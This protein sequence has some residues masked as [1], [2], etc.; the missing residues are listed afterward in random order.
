MILS[1]L[2][3][4]LGYAGAPW[5]SVVFVFALNLAVNA[6]IHATGRPMFDAM[7]LYE[8]PITAAVFVSA[9]MIGKLAKGTMEARRKRLGQQN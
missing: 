8:M 5:L 9:F 4:Y 2:C 6:V 7:T 1:I 3:L